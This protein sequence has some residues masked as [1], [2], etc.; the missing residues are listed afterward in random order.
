MMRRRPDTRIRSR[1]A[2]IGL[3]LLTL[4]ACSCSRK[5]DAALTILVPGDVNHEAL[6]ALAHARGRHLTREELLELHRAWIDNEVLYRE[7]LKLLSTPA[8]G[9]NREQIIARALSGLEQ[10]LQPIAVR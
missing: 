4:A 3:A 10:K 2:L 5:D 6:H 8:K 9:A 7:G 1:K